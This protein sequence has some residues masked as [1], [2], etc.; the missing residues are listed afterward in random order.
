MTTPPID[1][2]GAVAPLVFV[3]ALLCMPSGIGGG[4]LFVPV[5]RLIGGLSLKESTA[6]SQA[7]I[8]SASLAAT[9]FNFFEQYRARNDPKSLIVWPF[10]I[11]ILPGTVIGSLIGVYIYSWLPSL[12]VLI[13]YFCFACLGSFMA[14]RKGFRL[15]KAET[16][17]KKRESDSDTT[18]SG[19]S[20]VEAPGI[21]ALQRMP[22]TKKLIYYM[23]VVAVIWTICLIFPP[24]T[25]NSSTGSVIGVPYCEEVYWVLAAVQGVILLLIPAGYVAVERSPG[26][27]KTGS[28]LMGS[29]IVIGL[30]S[31]IVGI[32][33]G[34]FMIPVVLSLGLDPK[35]STATTAI[36]IFATSTSTALSFALGGY[37]PPAS[38]M[39]ITVMPFAG[40][41][42]GK[43]IVAK[44]LAMTG[45]L[46]VLVLLLGTMVAIGGITTI[47]T[48]IISVV[49]RANNGGDIVQFGSFC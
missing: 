7:L 1:N 5:L 18:D 19:S 27:V 15:W 47:T 39:W 9:L 11:L 46:S 26:T 20:P 37:F 3:I 49:N 23:T 21:P 31:S 4:V 43:T 16:R 30:I 25:G 36:V 35:Q 13:L 40:A 14:Y 28:I 32:S 29:M 41:L 2:L 6:L 34:L 44:L 17:A 42:L 45:R 38:D 24:L 48:G 8:A 33:G 22:S 10:V 12:F